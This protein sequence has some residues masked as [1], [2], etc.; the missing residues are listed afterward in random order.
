[1]LPG[2]N[3]NVSLNIIAGITLLFENN[4]GIDMP[5]YDITRPLWMLLKDNA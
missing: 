1:M 5:M 4:S 3:K 2:G